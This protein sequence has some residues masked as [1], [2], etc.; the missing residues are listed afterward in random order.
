MYK[1][2]TLLFISINC[3]I[4]PTVSIAQINAQDSLALIDLYN[5]T[6][7]SGWSVNS[8]WL[9]GPVSNW[10]GITTTGNTVTAVVLNG[11]N[12]IGTMPASLGNIANL[13]DLE[14][15]NN[16]VSGSIPTSLG[17]LTNL[18]ALVLGGNQLSGSIP[19][20]FGNLSSL[21]YLDL[22]SNQLSGNIPYS[23]GNLINLTTLSLYNNL[24]SGAIPGT[25]GELLSLGD[26]ELNNNQLSGAIP[27]SLKTLVSLNTLDLSSNQLSGTIPSTLSNLVNLNVLNL[28][29]NQ[30]TGNIPASL[31][32]ISSLNA[33]NLS[34][35]DL[36]GSIPTGIDN[37]SNLQ[38]INLSFNQLSGSIPSSLGKSNIFYVT[39]NNNLLS[40]TVPVSFTNLTSSFTSIN[41][42]NLTFDGLEPVSE[43]LPGMLVDSP[44]AILPLHLA[45]S[46]LSVYAGGTLANNTYHW[47]KDGVLYTTIVGDSTFNYTIP[48]HYSVAIT[49]SIVTMKSG[50]ILY[51][52]TLTAGI[53]LPIIFLNFTGTLVNNKTLLQWQ[54]VN[55]TNTSYFNVQQSLDGINFANISKVNAKGNSSETENYD[56]T[57][58]LSSII[59]Q[60]PST[61]FYRLQ[62]IDKDGSSIYSNIV[63][64]K[65]NKQLSPFTIYPNPVKDMLTI[66]VG[67]NS[68]NALITMFD[69]NGTRLFEQS[70]AMLQNKDIN[71][72][73]TN[74]AKGIYLIQININGLTTQQK[75]VKE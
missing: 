75:F 10:F 9:T 5:N 74:L 12:L 3:I 28:Y 23:L 65:L 32:T 52:D 16:Q 17:N 6:N 25:L 45:G 27:D 35:N 54:T 60:S 49:N 19:T 66:K 8:G 20:S 26:L 47:Y 50:L 62:E 72:N 31:G 48:G 34:S 44:Q 73:A 69:I 57:D 70:Q 43:A 37:L 63:D 42:N 39:L 56:Y 64:I 18:T 67:N 68:G 15:G 21:A 11:N 36:S 41:N 40:G 58:D 38:G 7:G 2:F 13:N 55:E 61:L 14:L 51:S 30:L 46:T 1:F 59:N 29:N 22:S 53:I 4:N 71:I 24:L 33:L